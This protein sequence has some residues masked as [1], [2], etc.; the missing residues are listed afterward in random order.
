LKSIS[1]DEIAEKGSNI[2][3]PPSQGLTLMQRLL[4]RRD[5]KQVAFGEVEDQNPNNAED[6]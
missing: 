5:M 6:A 3:E 1:I 4:R 2:G